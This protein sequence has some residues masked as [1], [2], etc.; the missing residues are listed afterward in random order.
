[1][2]IDSLNADEFM[3]ALALAG[4]AVG[5]VVNGK[6][7]AD[8]KAD[9]SAQ[10]LKSAE[11]DEDARKADSEAWAL[12]MLVRYIPRIMRENVEDAYKLLAA[13]DGQT[14]EEYKAAFTPVKFMSDINSLMRAFNEDGELRQLIAPFLA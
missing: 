8:I 11:L 12:D 4:E 14:L 1:M 3:R 2:R 7:G 6:L 13:V 9:I 10:R 5:N